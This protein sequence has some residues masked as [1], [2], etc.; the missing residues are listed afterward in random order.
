MFDRLLF[1]TDGSDGVEAVFD[2]VLAIAAHHGATLH[3]L[4]VADTSHDSVTRIGDDVIDV[5]EQE[6]ET[7]VAD[8]AARAEE[9]GIETET[10]VIQGGVP[11]TIT[12]YAAR[13]GIDCIVMPTHGRTGLEEFFLGSTTERVSRLTTV[14]VLTLRPDGQPISYPFESLLVPTDGSDPATRSLKF[15][16]DLANDTDG[17]LHLLSAVDVSVFGGS[18]RSLPHFDSLET[19]ATEVVDNAA[20]LA[21]TTGIE[22]IQTAVE[23][24]SSVPAAIRSYATEHDIGCIVMGTHGRTGLSRYLIGS[25]TE[26]VLRSSEHPVL[27]VP[28]K[29]NKSEGDADDATAD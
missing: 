5:F 26:A 4:H 8:T 12:G 17:T 23:H 14:P 11:K 29:T 28:S 16:V 10:A 2:Q 20:D 19:E 21:A 3:V 6:G 24:G 13:E 22:G 18:S 7:L 9:R 15:A 1:P 25:V 27:V